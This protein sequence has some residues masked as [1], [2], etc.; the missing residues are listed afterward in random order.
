MFPRTLNVTDHYSGSWSLRSDINASDVAFRV[1][2]NRTLLYKIP[3]NTAY[4]G[5]GIPL[6]SSEGD[7]ALVAESY[8]VID[9][10]LGVQ[11]RA[12]HERGAS[13]QVWDGRP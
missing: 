6:S 10:V 11:V 5:P 13:R 3:A 4:G 8:P 12:M 2:P 1:V 7:A 9:G